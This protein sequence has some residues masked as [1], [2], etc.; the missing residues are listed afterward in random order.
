MKITAMLAAAL[1]TASIGAYAAGTYDS[2]DAFY[3]VQAGAMFSEP[4][5]Q[6][7]G[8]VYSQ[9]GDEGAH[10]EL[11]TTFSGRVI[12]IQVAPDHI[13]VN[14]RTYRFTRATKFPHEPIG[15][16]YP[17]TANVFM[18]KQ[19]DNRRPVLC[20]EGH[21]SGSGEADRY[22]Q[23]FLLVDPFG[24]KPTFLHLPAL[25]SSCRA[26]VEMEGGQLAF[27]KNSYLFDE[28]QNARIG[29]L[30]SYFTFE[31]GQFKQTNKEIRLFFASPEN[32]FKFSRQ[33]ELRQSA[34]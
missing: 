12:R 24:R 23:I 1:A 31:R 30:V 20:V 28:A 25:L 16:I 15:N 33:D 14:D 18:A 9:P 19:A 22:Q 5:K 17:D 10:I 27:P 6:E 3:T 7:A 8:V 2:Y 29:L 13:T 21:G 11:H 34:P 32:P 4:I 26:I